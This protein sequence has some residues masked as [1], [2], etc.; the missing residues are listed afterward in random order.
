MG[1]PVGAMRP[2]G[3]Q[4]FAALHLA[5][6]DGP[7]IA[8]T[9]QHAAIGTHLQSLHRALMGLMHP[10]ALSLAQVPPA[11]KAIAATTDEPRASRA[12]GQRIDHLARLVPA[13]EARPRL[14]IPDE[15]VPTAPASTDTRQPR[16]IRAPS[17][18]HN[19]PLMPS[20]PLY[21]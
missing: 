20:H 4:V 17:N 11:E 18:A 2:Q 3:A 7:V 5:G 8:A 6:L 10:H 1:A 14:R 13:G 21:H 15:E 9:D 16:L 19:R 12:P